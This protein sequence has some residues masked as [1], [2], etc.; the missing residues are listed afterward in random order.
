MKN[1]DIAAAL[2]SAHWGGLTVGQKALIQA[3][4]DALAAPT[5]YRVRLIHM[6]TGV[7]VSERISR[8]PVTNSQGSV[9]RVEVTPLYAEE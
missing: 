6:A 1:K 2:Q 4:I 3:A 9:Y 7:L 8:A 5:A